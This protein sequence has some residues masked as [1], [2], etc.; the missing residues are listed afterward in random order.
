MHLNEE[1]TRLSDLLRL[2][3]DLARAISQERPQDAKRLQDIAKI[4]DAQ[5]QDLAGVAK[6]RS[7][8]VC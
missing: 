1:L 8:R 2:S 6:Q 7:S 4:V 3:A 5:A